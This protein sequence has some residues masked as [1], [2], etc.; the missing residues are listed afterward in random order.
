M[1]TQA[2]MPMMAQI[3]ANSIAGAKLGADAYQGQKNRDAELAKLLKGKEVDNANQNA[4][5]DKQLQTA[6]DLRER[7]G[8][9]TNVD[10]GDIKLGGVDPLSSLLKARELSQPKLTPGQEAA[11]KA[12]GKEYSD[13]TAGGGSKTAEKNLGLLQG[14]EKQLD[15]PG[16]KSPGI[17]E[18]G[19]QYLPD[20]FRA[21]LTP[22]IKAQEDSVRT[23]V[24]ATLRQTLGAQFTEKEGEGLMRRS[25]DARLS[26]QANLAKMRPEIEA[27]RAQLEQKQRSAQQFEN[28]GS[29][30]GLGAA[31]GSRAP[32]RETQGTPSFEQWKAMKAGR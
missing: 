17:F 14:V 21:A 20:S 16:A 31:G 1:V 15:D 27:L 25:Y 23:A 8:K 26:P 5:Y 22:K 11:D 32:Q 9:E 24:Q 7:Y 30:V 3:T 29:L 6:K 18:R 28:T 4:M 13:Y 12:F 19:V 2:D 10:A